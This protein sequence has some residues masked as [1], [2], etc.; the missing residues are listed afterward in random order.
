[1]TYVR[2]EKCGHYSSM[3]L[4][5]AVEHEKGLERKYL[6]SDT[7]P[8]KESVTALQDSEGRQVRFESHLHH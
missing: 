3:A 1:M 2:P 7:L 6:A 8:G 4:L 5:G